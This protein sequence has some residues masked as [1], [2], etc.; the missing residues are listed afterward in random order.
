VELLKTRVAQFQF[1]SEV[2]EAVFGYFLAFAQYVAYLRDILESGLA[3]E[4]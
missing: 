4:T 3:Q 1:G 2:E